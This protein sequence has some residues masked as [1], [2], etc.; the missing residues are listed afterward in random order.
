LHQ[1]K[2][3]YA[4]DTP[5]PESRRQYQKNLLVLALYCNMRRTLGIGYERKYY[6]LIEMH[7]ESVICN[8]STGN[9]NLAALEF[10][11][12]KTPCKLIINFQLTN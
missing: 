4:A 6:M 5:A 3:M 11:R 10:K 8:T 7:G 9:N 2:H 12:M 1:G